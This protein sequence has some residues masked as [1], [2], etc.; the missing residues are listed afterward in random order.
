MRVFASAASRRA[1][2]AVTAPSAFQF[3]PLSVEYH[4]VPLVVSAAVIATPSSAPASGSVTLSTC[5]AGL[6]KSTRLDTRVPTA[7][8]GAPAS[9]LTAFN[10]GLLALSRTG[11]VLLLV[12]FNETA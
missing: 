4:H 3:V 1:L 2:L 12:D 6:A 5:P 7:P 11:A 10:V 9:S 8:D